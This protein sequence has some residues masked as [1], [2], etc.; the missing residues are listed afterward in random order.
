M[1]AALERNTL[2]GLA[3]L[4]R[5]SLTGLYTRDGFLTLGA[6][7]MEMAKSRSI[8]FFAVDTY[9]SRCYK[10]QKDKLFGGESPIELQSAVRE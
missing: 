8:P 1:R 5:D 6:R 3:D 4:L 9:V 10:P 2:E 7:A